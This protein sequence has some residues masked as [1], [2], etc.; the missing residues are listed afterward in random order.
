MPDAARDARGVGNGPVAGRF[1][2]L[3]SHPDAQVYV[4]SWGTWEEAEAAFPIP[5][6]CFLRDDE[7]GRQWLPGAPYEWDASPPATS[8]DDDVIAF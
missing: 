5:F 7:T 1:V 8:E 3:E 4:T 6:M 2:L